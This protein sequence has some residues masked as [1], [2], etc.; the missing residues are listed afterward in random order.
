M[1]PP[2]QALC[3]SE[4]NYSICSSAVLNI[5]I[6][7]CIGFYSTGGTFE[8]NGF[9]GQSLISDNEHTKRPHRRTHNLAIAWSRFRISTTLRNLEIAHAIARFA[10]ILGF[11]NC[12]LQI[13]RERRT[14]TH[15]YD[16]IYTCAYM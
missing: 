16:G 9:R 6:D 3:Y 5:I 7:V 11:Q 2:P 1:N 8:L 4:L 15:N 14:Y 13:M 10:R 12:N